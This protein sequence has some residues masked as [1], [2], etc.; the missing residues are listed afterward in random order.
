MS[1]QTATWLKSLAFVL[2]GS[3]MMPGA[4]H[5]HDGW[6]VS[7]AALFL[8]VGITGLWATRGKS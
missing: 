2:V 7:V 8:F 4:V 6:N 5:S 3:A 1:D